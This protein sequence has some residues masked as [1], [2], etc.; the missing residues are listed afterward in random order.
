MTPNVKVIRSREDAADGLKSTEISL[1]E[2]LLKLFSYLIP[3]TN[4][5]K[6]I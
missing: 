2:K 3:T 4:N 1:C 5:P 6:S